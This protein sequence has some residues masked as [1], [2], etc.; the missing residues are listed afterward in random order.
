MPKSGRLGPH[1]GWDAF[2]C[3]G[4]QQAIHGSCA[5]T[6][7]HPKGGN[8]QYQEVELETLSLLRPRPVHKKAEL[9]MN[10]RNGNN[11][12]AKDPKG[13]NTSQQSDDETQSAEEFRLRLP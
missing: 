3:W 9:M 6:A 7:N 1:L 2:L 4:R 13:R 10:H 12:V 5:C 11:H 8:R